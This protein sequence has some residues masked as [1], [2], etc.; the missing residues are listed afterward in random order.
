[1]AIEFRSK[2]PMAWWRQMWD[3]SFAVASVVCSL[4][5][6]VAFGN[7]IWGIPLD[8]RREFAGT[9]FSLLNPYALLVGITTVALF[10][11]HGA[12][13]IVLKTE[14]E[15]QAL[16][17]GWVNNTIIFFVIC[18][19]IT[20]MATLLFV[21][22]MTRH[23]VVY[24]VLF[25][26]PLLTMLAIANIPREMHHGRDF[27]AFLSSGCTIAGLMALM[28]VGVFPYL[29]LSKP[30]PDFSLTIYNAASSPKTLVIM[31]LIAAIGVPIVLAYTASI[32]YIFRGK[33]KLDVMSY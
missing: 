7:I 29:V 33:V 20:T 30:N 28:A 13:F 17:R 25:V 2:Q 16:V 9:F 18:Y 14:G 1:V 3:V 21:P 15:L 4:L 24:P 27:L 10:M 5:L 6:G 32:Y 31:L 26:L 23:I 12:I 19:G 22:H 11:M 8:A